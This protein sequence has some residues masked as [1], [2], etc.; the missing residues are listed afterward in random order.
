MLNLLYNILTIGILV[1]LYVWA[2]YNIPILLAGA[3]NLR[4]GGRKGKKRLALSEKLPSI[5]IIVP[6]KDEERVIDRL[7][8]SFL[9]LNYP[10]EKREI[11][12]VDGGSLD[13]TVEICKKCSRQHPNQVRL[14]PHSVSH[15]KPPALNYALKHV[16]GE[17]IGV[18][19][20]DSVLD[21]NVLIRAAEY[22]QGSSVV[23]VQGR[24]QSINADQNLLTKFVSYEE[25][26]AF[27]IFLQG[28]DFL[29]L[30]VPLIGS[31]YF[32][33]RNIL[34]EIGGWD[35][36][37]LSE[38]VEMSVRLTLGGYDIKYAPDVECW[39]ESSAG[40]VQLISQ[41]IRWFRGGMEV[42]LKYG[43]LVTKP[44]RK[45]VDI[46]FTLAGSYIFPLCFF[47]LVMA[48]FGFFFSVQPSPLSRVIAQV[49]LL[50]TLILF[51]ITATALVY[52][53]NL[54][55]TRTLL[56]LPFIYVYWTIEAFIATY[57]LTRIVLKRT[58]R[59]KKTTR[60]G[61]VASSAL[62]IRRCLLR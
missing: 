17:I 37:S 34:E 14:L 56:W 21:P 1:V 24:T 39:Q 57:A 44:N 52:V 8:R 31:C 11:I 58:R 50:L 48:L 7:L 41:R 61:I 9:K 62:N 46:E 49:T 19:D 43:K 13:G 5:S 18:F 60:T 12:I 45:N 26:I 6:V 35:E 51:V 10:S 28:K 42:A 32:I 38:D 40:I 54:L 30:Y 16:K 4:V 33:R 27:E 59:W 2:F 29:N 55:G 53:T 20:A 23:A 25:T 47:G 15:G 36:N 22:F 3:K